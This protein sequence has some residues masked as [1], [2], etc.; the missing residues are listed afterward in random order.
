[1]VPHVST[2]K[3]IYEVTKDK[4]FDKLWA[5]INASGLAFKFRFYSWML[6]ARMLLPFRSERSN[7]FLP[8]LEVYRAVEYAIKN[9]KEIVYAERAIDKSTLNSLKSEKRMGISAVLLRSVI[10]NNK[11]KSW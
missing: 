1:M 5:P 7:P 8:G 10:F 2:N 4:M 6:I 11:I 3:D 9:N